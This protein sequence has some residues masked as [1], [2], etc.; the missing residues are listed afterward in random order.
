VSIDQPD[1]ECEGL[2]RCR[3]R[4]GEKLLAALVLLGFPYPSC[5][6]SEDGKR[7][8]ETL[9]RA[10]V[11]RNGAVALPPGAPELVLAEAPYV[12]A[13]VGLRF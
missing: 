4:I 13:A 2:G 8:Q 3:V 10:M 5:R 1:R 6:L 9:I 11:P 7:A 12:R